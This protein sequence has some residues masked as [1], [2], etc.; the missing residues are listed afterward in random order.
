MPKGFVY[1]L[2]CSDGSYYTGSTI[3]IEK[4]LLE[5]QSG[6][7]A[8]HT[9]KRLP[10]TLVYLE[11]HQR[12]DEAFL[13]EKQIQG[14]NRTKKEALINNNS[15]KL[16]ELSLAY[17]DIISKKGG[18]ENLSLQ[19]QEY[20]VTEALEGT[21]QKNTFF[22][23]GK[24]LLTGE[25]LVLD[26]ALS[27]ALPTK[28][29]QSL[30]IESLDKPEIH[31][32]SIDQK[33]N[34]W[35]ETVFSISDDRILSQNDDKVSNRLVQIFKAL[36]VLNPDFFDTT[37][38]FKIETHLDFNREWGLGTS[39][40]LINNLATWTKVDAYELLKLT[41]GGS[42]YDIACA[43]HN[44]AI[45]Y[46][47]IDNTPIVTPVEFN[48][49]FKEHLYFVY[50]NTKRNSR[51]AIN[52]YKQKRPISPSVIDDINSIT[53]EVIHSTSLTE[54]ERL[55]SKH[56]NIISKIIEQDTVKS[57]YFSDFD[58]S[59]KS[60]GAWGGDFVLATSR[61]NPEAYFK[62]KGFNTIIP[63]SDLIL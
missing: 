52:Q 17:R 31:W 18:F 41:F 23:N 14:W 26:G 6:H 22:S 16:P 35:Y 1:I 5:H 40:T 62:S 63:Y 2:K 59:I 54:F 8:N 27:L 29:G 19:D 57:V 13:R 7:G 45:T 42:G 44:S 24:L 32:K 9:K 60:L 58:G 43:Q 4:R 39:S 12:I 48:P 51:D 53:E 37:S 33:A 30:S 38:G 56:E 3:D 36:K 20:M 46:Q 50:L 55:I 47:L 15:H 28:P 11:E 61:T 21:N 49:E 34:V 10:V 25:Y